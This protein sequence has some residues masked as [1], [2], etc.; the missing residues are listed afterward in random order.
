MLPLHRSVGK[1]AFLMALPL[2]ASLLLLGCPPKPVVTP[3]TAT[4]TRTPTTGSLPLA[5]TFTD[6]STPGTSSITAWAWDFGDGATSTEQNPVHTYTNAGKY[7][8]SLTVTTSAGSDVRM[9]TDLIVV[10][11][12][13]PTVSAWPTAGAITYN[14]TLTSSTLIGGEASVDGMFTFDA[15]ATKPDTGSYSA[16]V[17]FTPTDT[18]N[19]RT[20]SGTVGVTVNNA[21]PTVSAWPAASAITYGQTLAASTLGVGTASVPGVY[22]FNAP[23]TMPNGGTYAAAVTF[24]PTDINHY[25][26]VPGMVN[27]TVNK[28]TTTVSAWPTASAIY[29]NQTLASSILT[30]GASAVAG[31][32]SFTAPATTPNAGTYAAAVTFTPAA[33]GNYHS[34]SG[35]A[36]VTVYKATP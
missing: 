19:Y 5:V 22:W 12:A 34:V 9:K 16:A 36:D 2:L 27:V 4:F 17:T 30:G 32:F 11:K 29:Y 18:A 35:T 28:A 25:N 21:T 23:T 1:T 6:T 20:A 7:S 13:T 15:P 14:Q 24:T 31:L 26:T 33:S 8:V 3:P 10:D